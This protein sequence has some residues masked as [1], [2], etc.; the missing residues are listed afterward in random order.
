MFVTLL[1]LGEVVNDDQDDW[2]LILRI[3]NSLGVVVFQRRV[4]GQPLLAFLHLSQDR[5]EQLLHPLRLG[6][7]D[8]GA[9]MRE[10]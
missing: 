2:E 1:K 9:H 4:G 10:L 5:P 8:R 3:P 6:G 7:V